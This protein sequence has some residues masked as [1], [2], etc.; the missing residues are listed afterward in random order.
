M[1]VKRYRTEILKFQFLAANDF[2]FENDEFLTLQDSTNEFRDH[3]NIEKGILH[4]KIRVIFR[5]VACP[6]YTKK[7]DK[8][9]SLGT[10]DAH[11]GSC[12]A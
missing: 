9:E 5:S 4:G 8:S 3:E 10:P 12:A 7:C 6:Q 1:A 2:S 11:M